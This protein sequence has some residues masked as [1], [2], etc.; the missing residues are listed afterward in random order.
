MAEQ[1]PHSEAQFEAIFKAHYPGMVL[2]ANKFVQDMD[3]AK[4]LAQQVFVTVFE[5]R[6]DLQIKTS[7]KSYLF[8]AVRN[9]ALNSLN[10]KKIHQKHEA[11]IIGLQETYQEEGR[12]LELLEL[13]EKLHKLIDELPPKCSQIFKLNRFEGKKNKEIAETLNISIRTVETQISK[14]LKILREKLPKELISF[15][16]FFFEC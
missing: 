16:L 4:D 12:S 13:T 14:A 15:F 11:N 9:A 8:Q 5:K 6:K 10:Q 3:T 1:I 2:Y 7:L